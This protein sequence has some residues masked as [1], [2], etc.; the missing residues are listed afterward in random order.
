MQ[1]K[2]QQIIYLLGK[3]KRGN[4]TLVVHW[5]FQR[6]VAMHMRESLK[7]VAPEDSKLFREQMDSV[8]EGHDS[9]NRWSQSKDLVMVSIASQQALRLLEDVAYKQ[10]YDNKGLRDGLVDN[11]SP[12]DVLTKDT[13]LR[14]EWE[15]VLS[16]FEEEVRG[17]PSGERPGGNESSD[18]SSDGALDP[19]TSAF[20]PNR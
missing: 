1:E 4:M 16:A 15:A 11:Q 9:Y 3:H 18:E 20:L 7:D 19:E 14:S 10:T 13:G 17:L 12:K 5:L 8:L 2:S 6:D